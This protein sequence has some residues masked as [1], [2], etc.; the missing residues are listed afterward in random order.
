MQMISG[1]NFGGVVEWLD[2]QNTPLLLESQGQG[3]GKTH[4][5]NNIE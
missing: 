2:Q 1:T 4:W 5:D 3:V